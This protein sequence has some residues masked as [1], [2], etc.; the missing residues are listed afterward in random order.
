MYRLYNESEH[1]LRG[2]S[3]FYMQVNPTYKKTLHDKN[4]RPHIFKIS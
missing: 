1:H 4:H 3:N 2:N